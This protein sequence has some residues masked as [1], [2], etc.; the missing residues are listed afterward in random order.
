M[1]LCSITHSLIIYVCSLLLAC[2][3]VLSPQAVAARSL[4]RAQEFAHT[5]GIPTAYGSYKELLEDDRIDAVYNPLP[6]SLHMP[7]SVAA[8]RAGKHVLCEKPMCQNAEEAMIM[9]RESEDARKV[10]VEAFHTICHP[11][12][13]RARDL[14]RSGV[15]GAVQ[16]YSIVHLG[17]FLNGRTSKDEDVRLDVTLGGGCMMDLGCYDIMSIRF[18]CD[19][20]PVCTSATADIFVG[21]PLVDDAM[22]ASGTMSKGGTFSISNSWKAGA[23]AGPAR[24]KITGSKGTLECGWGSYNTGNEIRISVNGAENVVESVDGPFPNSRTTMYYQLSAFEAEIRQQEAAGNCGMPWAY[25]MKSCPADA[26]ANM[27]ALDRVYEAAGIGRRPSTNPPPP[28][29]AKL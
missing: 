27:S 12:S 13:I 29:P 5:H 22:V 15:I 20:E 14:V 21:D 3:C 9:Q 8:L 23:E 11:A 19:S 7:L 4:E 17:D 1:S 10:L 26:V 18:L 2:T 6:N 25:R 28:L 16:D 24:I